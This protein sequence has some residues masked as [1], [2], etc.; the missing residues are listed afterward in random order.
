MGHSHFPVL[1]GD[2]NMGLLTIAAAMRRQ[3]LHINVAA[4]FAWLGIR[5]SGAIA[6]DDE[7]GPTAQPAPG[8]SDEK[9][10]DSCTIFLRAL[11]QHQADDHA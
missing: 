7:E 5:A 4:W 11:P 9:M 6:E 1:T 8:G 2:F 3:S 10:I